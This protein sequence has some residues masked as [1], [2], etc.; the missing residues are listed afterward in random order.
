MPVPLRKLLCPARLVTR[1]SLFVLLVPGSSV[2]AVAAEPTTSTPAAI[3]AGLRGEVVLD[4]ARIRVEKF[5]L[6]PG[7][8]T[9]RVSHLADQLLVFVKGGVLKSVATGRATL[10]RD[11]RVVW[12]SAGAP[13]EEG[14][15]NAGT[16][17]IVMMWVTVKPVAVA[18]TV[19]ARP[20]AGRDPY[21]GYL[22]YPNIPGEDLLEND[23]VIVQRF[24]VQ[25]GEWEGVHAHRPN[26]L[27]IH[28]KGGYWA[29]RTNT[30]PVRTYPPDP[31]GALDWQPTFDISEGH[32]SGNV[33]K[34][35][36]DIIWVSL[37]N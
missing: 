35:P 30:Q 10:W 6:Q 5:G 36:I 11:G 18:P 25:P 31:D 33:G 1:A 9:G 8:S 24:T 13:Q 21:G 26:M 37:K 4:N 17:P 34:E 16:T 14:S 23:R 27:Y 28:I 32:Q 12:Q 3:Y 29:D 7:Q 22:N 15:T 20:S 19:D 2:L